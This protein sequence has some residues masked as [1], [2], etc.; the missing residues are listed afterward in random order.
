M[1]LAPGSNGC[2]HCLFNAAAVV[3]F[4]ASLAESSY[5]KFALSEFNYFLVEMAIHRVQKCRFFSIKV[6][7]LLR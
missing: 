1:V 7:Q 6:C 4:W 2:R 3:L 5:L